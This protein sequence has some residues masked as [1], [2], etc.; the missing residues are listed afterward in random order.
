METF[1]QGQI[2]G[3][4]L[5]SK[6]SYELS[7]IFLYSKLN[8]VFKRNWDNVRKNKKICFSIFRVH[9]SGS[10]SRSKDYTTFP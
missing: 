8:T 10:K 4:N 5:M 9:N 2:W 3:Q 7:S 1:I 6:L